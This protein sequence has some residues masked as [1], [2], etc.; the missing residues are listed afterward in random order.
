MLLLRKYTLFRL[1]IF[2]FFVLMI[3]VALY[4]ID[5]NYYQ[6]L[7]WEYMQE[8]QPLYLHLEPD[9]LTLT[10]E[11]SR[12]MRAH[13]PAQRE[14]LR[15]SLESLFAAALAEPSN[16]VGLELR[17][18]NGNVVVRAFDDAK[19][20]RRNR[21]PNA[22][23]LRDFLR[24]GTGEDL[25]NLPDPTR[26]GRL[27]YW[28]T[29]PAGDPFIQR[30]TYRFAGIALLV[31]PLVLGPFFL[32]DRY[33]M[34]PYGTVVGQIQR[35]AQ[36][37]APR[38]I[39]P[40]LS[41]LEQS[42]NNLAREAIFHDIEAH[43]QD[44]RQRYRFEEGWQVLEDLPRQARQRL[45]YGWMAAI[46]A[47]RH[48]PAASTHTGPSAGDYELVSM[49]ADGIGPDGTE[50]REAWCRACSR[51]LLEPRAMHE[52]LELVAPADAT[53]LP[54]VVPYLVRLGGPDLH[55]CLATIISDPAMPSHLTI[56][57]A[58]AP[59]DV[60]MPDD[61]WETETFARLLAR[62]LEQMKQLALARQISA[63][64]RN[65][66]NISL[67]RNLGHDLSNIIATSKLDL[68][69]MERVMA[70][71]GSQPLQGPPLK[72]LQA[73]M[74]GLLNNARYMQEVVDLYRSF[75]YMKRPTFE[76]LDI[77]PLVGEILHVFGLSTSSRLHL[78]WKPADAL[79]LAR[80]EPRL[81]KLAIFNVLNNALEAL[82]RS[83]IQAGAADAPAGR[84]TSRPTIRVSTQATEGCVNLIIEDNGPGIRDRDGE[85]LPPEEMPRI[86]ALGY[87]TKG[88][89][90]GEGLGLNWVR[91]IVVDF[92]QGTIRAENALPHGARFII[93][94]PTSSVSANPLAGQGITES[95]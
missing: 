86:F 72:A 29:S 75:S 73:S 87:S 22:L 42:Y 34:R 48:T 31:L 2:G 21:F 28:W 94:L 19:L 77:N 46:T 9:R 64:E 39:R 85:P 63:R 4:E 1:L 54:R 56:L 65:E 50:A 7:K 90:E 84:S 51:A 43:Y 95:T 41:R 82:K 69:T 89:G 47:R 76:V 49:A 80:L 71:A 18:K 36:A 33:F 88:R 16:L 40:A 81:L 15:E 27:V 23:I 61:Q 10:R 8:N 3:G 14:Q 13:S 35:A 60:L 12:F 30:L 45:G 74:H 37:R 55:A 24:R 91:T 83:A 26:N 53:A 62:T 70:R 93:A 68:L 6:Q 59:E 79:P 11:A 67:A 92:H 44:P 38:L 5:R 78:E 66:A 57:L 17:D 20:A 25:T 32:L 52:L 58:G